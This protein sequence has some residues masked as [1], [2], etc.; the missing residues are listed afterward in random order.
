MD[1]PRYD[2]DCTN[3]IFL[4]QYDQYD[5]YFCPKNDGTIAT[6]IARKSSEGPDYYSGLLVAS[7]P[8]KFG[9]MGRILSIALERAN[10]RR[11]INV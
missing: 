5:L 9:E 6:V 3:C 8:E 7:N 2:H 4:E 11:S 10:E 1:S